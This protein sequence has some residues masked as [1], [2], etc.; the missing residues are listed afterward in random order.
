MRSNAVIL[1]D[2]I[3]VTFTRRRYGRQTYTWAHANINAD[4]SLGCEPL[5]DPWPCMTP[6]ISE[7]RAALWYTLMG[8]VL[9]PTTE[10][11][12]A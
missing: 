8:R 4:T 2:G 6:K 1:I 10:I 3:Q 11:S 9:P 7:L 5:G 12:H